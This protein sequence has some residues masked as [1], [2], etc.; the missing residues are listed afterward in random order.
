MLSAKLTNAKDVARNER[1][2]LSKHET[3]KLEF[4]S[5][6]LIKNDE[7]EHIFL[8]HYLFQDLQSVFQ[9]FFFFFFFFSSQRFLTAECTLRQSV[10][11]LIARKQDRRNRNIKTGTIGFRTVRCETRG[12][13]GGGYVCVVQIGE[14]RREGGKWCA[15]VRRASLSTRGYGRRERRTR[16]RRGVLYVNRDSERERRETEGPEEGERE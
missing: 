6:E 7:I 3:L 1:I 5:N 14:K 16:V 15:H 9:S 8:R 13:R 11:A 4:L 2:T 10:D 12:R